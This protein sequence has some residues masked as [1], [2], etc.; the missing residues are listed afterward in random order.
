MVIKIFVGPKEKEYFEKK[1]ALMGWDADEIETVIM[2]E[3]NE[4][5]YDM[6][7]CAPS[8][9]DFVEVDEYFDEEEAEETLKDIA[10]DIEE[11]EIDI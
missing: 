2:K 8:G 3:A 10:E 11:D 5:F 6:V 1:C 4:C 7:Q 9:I